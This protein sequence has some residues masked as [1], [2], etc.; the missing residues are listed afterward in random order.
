MN[1]ASLFLRLQAWL[2]QTSLWLATKQNVGEV[3]SIFQVAGTCKVYSFLIALPEI[4]V[5]FP[6]KTNVL[7]RE[8]CLQ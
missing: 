1:S 4:I 2:A 3:L 6:Q 8:T 7:S 5:A